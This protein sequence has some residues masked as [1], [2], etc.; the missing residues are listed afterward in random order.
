MKK[1]SISNIIPVLLICLVAAFFAAC[2]GDSAGANK[3]YPIVKDGKWGYINNQG[4]IVI[5]PQ[6][7]AARDFHDGLA[8]VSKYDKS[9]NTNPQTMEDKDGYIDETGKFV[10]QPQFVSQKNIFNNSSRVSADNFSEGL[11]IVQIDWTLTKSGTLDVLQRNYACIDKTGKVVFKLDPNQRVSDNFS[12]GLLLFQLESDKKYGYLDK[13]GKVAIEPKYVTALPF[14]EGLAAVSTYTKKTGEMFEGVYHGYIDTTG[15][16]KINLQ[17]KEAG[18]F[19]EGL[20]RVSEDGEFFGF[21]DKTD[22]MIIKPQ[23]KAAGDFHD[24]LV[25]TPSSIGYRYVDKTGKEA[26]PEVNGELLTNFSEGLAV[27]ADDKKKL[28]IIDKYGKIVAPVEGDI[29]LTPYKTAVGDFQGGLVRITADE[30]GVDM[31][32]YID[33]KGKVVWKEKLR[34]L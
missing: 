14:S 19:H 7:D 23:L 34:S 11:A 33:K 31:L 1:K 27:I 26:F 18:S 28:Q 13:T 3:L 6:F 22:K 10:I 30:K 21:I 15:N 25:A 17:F 4:K 16:T 9:G 24:G 2:G 32:F 5:E 29:T 12:D 8:L 20:A